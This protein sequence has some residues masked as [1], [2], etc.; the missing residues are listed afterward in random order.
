MYKSRIVSKTPRDILP[1][2]AVEKINSQ[3]D[4]NVN[5]T[6]ECKSRRGLRDVIALQGA[7]SEA[8]AA[9]C[10]AL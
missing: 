9:V 4:K 6:V 8:E 5:K 3:N 1:T 7:L 2:V 10:D